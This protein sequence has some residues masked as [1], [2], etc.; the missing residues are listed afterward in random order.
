[1]FGRG[2]LSLPAALRHRF[3]TVSGDGADRRL[4]LLQVPSSPVGQ[5]RHLTMLI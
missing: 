1:M 2:P 4:G 5:G 3:C